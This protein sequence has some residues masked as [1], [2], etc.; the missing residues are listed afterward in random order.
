[1]LRSILLANA[2]SCALFGLIFVF[3][4]GALS[5]FIGNPPVLLVRVLGAALLLNG[6]ALFWTAVY[7]PESRKLVLFFALGDAAWV[8][9]TLGLLVSKLWITTPAGIAWSVGL[10]I[11]VGFCGLAQY[12]LAPVSQG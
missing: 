3:E 4:S 9:A 11:F 7:A 2:L 5:E 6:A 1:M 10:A 8:L 12:R